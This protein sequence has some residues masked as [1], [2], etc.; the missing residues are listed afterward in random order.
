[1]PAS[2]TVTSLSQNTNVPSPPI[3]FLSFRL[4]RK[5]ELHEVHRTDLLVFML[6]ACG[7]SA[8]PITAKTLEFVLEA[9]A[10]EGQN[11]G[12]VAGA[13][14]QDV[15]HAGIAVVLTVS[16]RIARPAV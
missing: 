9:S 14:S 15:A 10:K 7:N 4:Q 11:A 6:A 3:R 12:A 16:N 5:G 13:L 1:M 8:P 2:V